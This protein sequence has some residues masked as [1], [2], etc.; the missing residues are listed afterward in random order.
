MKF[1]S[2]IE[3][4]EIVQKVNFHREI[5]RVNITINILTVIM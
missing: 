2:D 1:L 3:E 5:S 4:S